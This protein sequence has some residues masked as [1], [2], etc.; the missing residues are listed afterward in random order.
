MTKSMQIKNN[1]LYL[2]DFSLVAL[3]EKYQTPLMVFDAAHL[4]HRMNEF[5]EFT[6][7]SLFSTQLVYASKAF[8]APYLCDLMKKAG[9]FMDATS[10]GDLFIIEQSGF[11]LANVVFHGNNKSLEELNLAVSRGVGIIVV[12]HVEELKKIVQLAK[13]YRCEVKTMVRINPGIEAHTHYYSQTSLLSSKFGISIEDFAGLDELMQ[14]YLHNP[15]VRLLGFHAHIGSQI[16]DVKP[17]LACAK[18]MLEFSKNTEN[19]YQYPLRHLNLGGGFGIHYTDE[20]IDYGKNLGLLLHEIVSVMHKLSYQLDTLYFEPGRAIVGEAGITL[21]TVDYVKTTWGGK[22]YLFID[23]G[24]TDNIRPALY[25]AKY[26]VVNASTMVAEKTVIADVVGKCCESGDIIA[27]D[28]EIPYPNSG[29]IL[30]VLSTGAYCY[31]MAMNYNS[32]LRPEVI[33]VEQDQAEAV[34]L[35]ET[36]QDLRKLF[37][38]K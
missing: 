31:P 6:Q 37:P 21:Y 18:Q 30:A 36:Y 2:G 23:G 29:D 11:P 16:I 33:V 15:Q 28:V 7:S 8:L 32:A 14:I 22:K 13:Q 24:M 5:K 1:Q 20:V 10:G 34:C 38:K 27:K 3:A 35:R 9:W 26:Q 25:Q 19:Q 4:K 17:F 12:D